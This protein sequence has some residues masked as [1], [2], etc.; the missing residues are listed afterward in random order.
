[1][2]EMIADK[3][4]AL[5][6]TIEA[7]RAAVHKKYK[8]LMGIG[9]PC[10]VVGIVIGALM[11]IFHW[12]DNGALLFIPVFL[13]VP[14]LVLMIVAAFQHHNYSANAYSLLVNTIDA[15]LFPEAKKD[16]NRGLVL[17]VLL[18][19]GFFA[20]PDRYYGRNYKTATYNGIPFE[21]AGY[22]LQRRESH[23]DSKGNTYYTY[24][25]YAKARCTVSN[26]NGISLPSSNSREERHP[27]F[28]R[29]QFEES[30]HRI[31]RLQ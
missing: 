18:K 2:A 27:F 21:Q 31:H 11:A 19:P 10:F 30:R 15:T 14:G 1:M 17:N 13:V 5:A 20:S 25:T 6:Q 16:P 4:P 23:T 12:S 26:S 24:E 22:D 28:R 7:S 3:I 8:I 9:I 29:R